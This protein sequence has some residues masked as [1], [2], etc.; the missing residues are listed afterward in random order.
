MGPG[1]TVSVMLANAPTM[2]ECH[3][4]VPMCGAVLH[5]INTRLDAAVVV[6]RE[7]MDLTQQALALA[8][9]LAKVMPSVIQYDNP[10][11]G[12][13][14]T[15]TDAPDYEAFLAGGDPDFDWLMPEDEWDAISINCTS[16]TTGDPNQPISHWR[17]VCTAVRTDTIFR[18]ALMC[19][20]PHHNRQHRRHFQCRC[21]RPGSAVWH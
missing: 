8:L 10:K 13:S 6:D 16:G 19:F 9:A 14:P 15:A 18:G 4:G 3:Y 12:G 2:L 5:A 11:Y 7:F 1:D 20:G 21:R 17:N